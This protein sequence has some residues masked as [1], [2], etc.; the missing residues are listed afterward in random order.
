M[1][2]PNAHKIPQTP[3]LKSCLLREKVNVLELGTGCGIIGIS[4]A[5]CFEN[6]EVVITDLPE[7]KDIATFNLEQNRRH[8]PGQRIAV[9]YE[10]L[11]WTQAVTE[12]RI[13]NDLDLI[14]AGDV[15]YNS[16]MI[17]DLVK[18]VA[19]LIGSGTRTRFLVA[20]KVRHDSEAV[21]FDLMTQAG[22]K[23]VE[24]LTIPMPVLAQDDQA[25]EIYLFGRVA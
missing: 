19:S 3:L 2:L 5:I 11:D 15:T 13:S 23:I 21:F 25:I 20:M 24:R 18:T 8:G 16:D 6:V 1:S 9:T 14:V 22:L 12:R 10:N 4:L 17:P 7:A